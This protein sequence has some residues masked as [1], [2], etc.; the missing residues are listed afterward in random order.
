MLEAKWKTLIQRLLLLIAVTLMLVACE[1]EPP[2]TII[3]P[4]N[5]DTTD[6]SDLKALRQYRI[7]KKEEKKEVNP[8][9]TAAIKEAALTVGAQGALAK[10][11]EE[12]NAVLKRDIPQLDKVYR[13]Q[14]LMLDHNVLPPVLVQGD[15]LL[16]LNDPDT[17]R[18]ADSTFKIEQQARFVTA[19]PTWRDYLWLHYKKPEL[20]DKSILPKNQE[21]LTIWQHYVAIG[22]KQGIKQANSIFSDSLSRLTRD[23]QGMALYRKLLNQHMISAPFVAKT[24]LGITGGGSKITINDQVLRITAKPQLNANSKEWTPILAEP[25]TDHS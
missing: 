23:Y 5:A 16:N 8:I 13:F 14:A 20:P 11:S 15:N 9:R 25:F 18:L 19:P 22:W 4:P 10:R 12:I 6:L 3:Y 7:S 17:I 2:P 1:S 21:E 24:D